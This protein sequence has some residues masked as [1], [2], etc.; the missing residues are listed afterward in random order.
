[1][2]IA[3]LGS[4]IV[5]AQP[6]QAAAGFYISNGRLFDANGQDFVMRGVNHPH[7]WYTNRLGSLADIKA[8]GANTV[9][10]V[11]SATTSTS[12]DVA[13]VVSRCRA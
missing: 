12:G 9:R 8:T 5:V 1:M 2:L 3:L 13:N 4:I 6:A 11:L 10:V 7:A